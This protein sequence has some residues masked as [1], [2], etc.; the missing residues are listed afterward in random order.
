MFIELLGQIVTMLKNS[1][2][3]KE[4]MKNTNY[5]FCS[6]MYG[7]YRDFLQTLMYKSYLLMNCYRL[8]R[9]NSYQIWI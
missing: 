7:F 4:F 3:H 9:I 1:Y 8:L 5:N 2:C 6:M